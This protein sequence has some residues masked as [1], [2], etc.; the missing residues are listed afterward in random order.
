MHEG[1]D[2]CRSRQGT[3]KSY[4]WGFYGSHQGLNPRPASANRVRVIIQV[5]IVDENTLVLLSLTEI[6]RSA[7]S[8][9]SEGVGNRFGY[10]F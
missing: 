2:S 10:L 1:D 3:L 5:Q 4:C 7:D 8:S 6:T 9:S